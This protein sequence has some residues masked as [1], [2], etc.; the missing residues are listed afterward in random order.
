MIAGEERTLEVRVSNLSDRR[1][2]VNGFAGLCGDGGCIDCPSPLPLAIEP[3]KAESLLVHLTASI[4][5]VPLD[6]ESEIYLSTGVVPI[7]F[8]GNATLPADSAP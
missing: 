8:T 5:G 1:V 7:R 2:V 3:G 6:L 4:E